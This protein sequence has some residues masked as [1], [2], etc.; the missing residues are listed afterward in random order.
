[1]QHDEQVALASGAQLALQFG[2]TECCSAKSHGDV[3]AALKD[4]SP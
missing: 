3:E 1:M 2:A 4:T